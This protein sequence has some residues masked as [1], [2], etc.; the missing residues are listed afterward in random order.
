MGCPSEIEIGESFT[1]S[2]TTHDPD[3]GVNTDADSAPT[4]RIYEDDS[5][6]PFMSGT[7]TKKDDT[8]TTGFYSELISG[9]TGN[10]FGHN[11]TYTVQIDATVDSDQGSIS[12]G[13]K[14]YDYRKS[15]LQKW[16]GQDVTLS[17]N[18]RPDVNVDE[19]KDDLTAATNLKNQYDGSTGLSGDLYP[20][21][22]GQVSQIGS[23]GGSA[24]N[25]F[26]IPSPNGFVLTTGNEITNNEDATVALDG[27]LHEITDD[28]GEIDGYYILNIGTAFS[29]TNL[30]HD[31]R[32]NSNNDNLDIYVN[33]NTLASPV[34]VKRGTLNGTNLN[35]NL[36][37]IFPLENGDVMVGAD[38]G[39]VA[40]RFQNT[41]LTTATL[42]TDQILIEKTT[43]ASA[44]GYSNGAIWVDTV[45]GTSG[46]VD[47]YN[48]IARRPV[49]WADAVTLSALTG[50]KK[51]EIINGS[52]ITFTGS[53]NSYNMTGAEWD[54]D[55]NSQSIEGL[56]VF[57]ANVTGIGTATVT[58]PH[59]DQCHFGTT[60]LPPC[61][62]EN[63]GIGDNSGTFT[64]GSA[65]QFVFHNC[66]SMVPGDGTPNFVF[67]GLGS[68]TGINNRGWTGGSSYTLDSDCTL[69]HGVLVGGGTTI[70]TGGADVE[71]RGITRSL[72]I[73]MSAAETVQFVGTTGPIDISG[74][75]TGTVNLYGVSSILTD[76][77]TAATITDK[78]VSNFNIW[79]ELLTGI[80]HNTATS[81]GKRLR[82]LASAVILTGTSPNTGGTANTSTRIELDSNASSVNGAYDPAVITI[83]GGTGIGQSRQIYEYDGNN[84]Y[85]YVNRDWKTIPDN[86]T[87]YVI[88]ADAGNTHVNEGV[89][90]G[91]AN[92]TITLNSLASS[93]NNAYVGQL[94]FLTAGTGADQSRR[95]IAYDG[96][97]KIAT[98]DRNWGINPAAGTIYVMLPTS[99]PELDN[100]DTTVSSRSSHSAADVW[101][102]TPRTL[103]SFGTLVADIATA[104]WAETTR[105]LTSFGTLVADTAAA[106]WSYV[107]RTLTSG[108]G[109]GGD[110]TEAKQDIIIAEVAG[111]NGDSIP[112]TASIW[113]YE[114][115]TLTS[116]SVGGGSNEIVITIQDTD[117]NNI[118]GAFVELFDSANTS[119]IER[120]ITDASGQSTFNQNNGTFTVRIYKTGYSFTNQTLVVAADVNI[121]YQGTSFVRATPSD[122]N[123]VI[124][125]GYAFKAD[126]ATPVTTLEATAVILSVP[127]TVGNKLHSHE[128]EDATYDPTTGYFSF[129]IVKGALVE[130]NIP[131]FGLVREKI[132][133][134]QVDT[135]LSNL[136]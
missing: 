31:G 130:F 15:N 28:A 103:T 100:L 110:A 9:T 39:K 96:S 112:S 76:T 18:N 61:K 35:T 114:T 84:K 88:T 70:I 30:V 105:T 49:P 106:V 1:I 44:A 46:T 108:G 47:G 64:A 3:T 42:R 63:S 117:S 13:F 78:T 65:G 50:I 82:D 7:M 83:V 129:E 113:N 98:L 17:S 87:E 136:L 21:T 27:I 126:G 102:T 109:G 68:T 118:V 16:I 90:Q 48:G 4:Y 19:L 36:R 26:V 51:F 104:V 99:L 2:V 40:V 116:L 12:Y 89:A 60:T 10:G 22:Q 111:L 14:A 73:T 24:G 5:D 32:I 124:I 101:T 79:E 55:L 67:T 133:I 71:V 33:T 75:T 56:S 52:S 34:W 72:T 92:N 91:G 38:A 45:N 135:S 57:G 6:L 85:A 23:G 66:H 43:N 74:T 132:T 131:F 95:V 81:A 127:E 122:P 69:S 59:F 94:V 20:A 128:R 53:A 119:F 11:K 123:A 58:Q 80:N 54:L 62:I 115:R 37:R 97:T 134:P 125:D 41:G 107:T 29:P 120:V 77:T 86:T 25:E 93:L 8:N 121:T